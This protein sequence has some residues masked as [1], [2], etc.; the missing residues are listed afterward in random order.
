MDMS[1]VHEVCQNHLARHSDRGKKTRQ[2]E[3]EMGK[4]HQGMDRLEFAKSQRAVENREKG[5][6]RCEIICGAPT[7]LGVKGYVK[8]TVIRGSLLLDPVGNVFRY[9]N[10]H[11]NI[12][13]PNRPSLTPPFN[14]KVRFVSST[15]ASSRYFALCQHHS[16]WFAFHKQC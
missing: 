2:T 7:T 8:V 9:S 6:K 4:Q 11:T 12:F 14:L 10:H 1:S 3:E 16:L 5:R 15:K 13:P